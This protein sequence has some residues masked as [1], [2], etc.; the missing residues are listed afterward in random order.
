MNA[1]LAE[2]KIH[3]TA[4]PHFFVGVIRADEIYTLRE[5]KRRLQITS[6]TL[7]S[8]RQAGLP[9]YYAHKQGFIFGSDWIDYLRRSTGHEDT[10]RGRG[11]A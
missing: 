5:F 3:S 6:A 8:A 4:P 2:P 9:V 11:H 1:K 10:E 7:R